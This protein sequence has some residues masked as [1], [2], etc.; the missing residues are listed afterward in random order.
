MMAFSKGEVG[1]TLISDSDSDSDSESEEIEINKLTDASLLLQHKQVASSPREKGKRREVKNGCVISLHSNPDDDSSA[2]LINHPEETDSLKQ[3]QRA[4]LFSGLIIALICLFQA[5]PFPVQSLEAL[6]L[7]V[8]GQELRHAVTISIYSTFLISCLLTPA[9]LRLISPKWTI[10]LGCAGSFVYTVVRLAPDPYVVVGGALFAGL[11]QG[12][13]M[14]TAG[15]LIIFHGTQY[16]VFGGHSLP[17]VLGVF[18]GLFYACFLGAPLINSVLRLT[19]LPLDYDASGSGS[20][21]F[22]N[23]SAVTIPSESPRC[24]VHYCW[25][26]HVYDDSISGNTSGQSSYEDEADKHKMQA[27]LG[28]H[29]VCALGAW[30]LAVVALERNNKWTPNES[31]Y[32]KKEKKKCWNF[33]KDLHLAA[34]VLQWEDINFG[35]L[36][37]MMVYLGVQQVVGYQ[38]VL[39]VW[40]LV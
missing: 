18:N 22:T 11:T 30:L 29:I 35:M 34:T 1:L 17:N 28:T 26:D 33:I 31:N 5:V 27:L 19:I 37:V 16:A 10:C 8:E 14:A 23:D 36:L 20:S 4:Q 12:A 9:L 24:G 21:H 2:P 7:N 38:V 15:V 39:R 6:L 13:L 32:T 25:T 3:K 40:I